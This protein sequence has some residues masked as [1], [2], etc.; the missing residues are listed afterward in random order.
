MIQNIYCDERE[1]SAETF[2]SRGRGQWVSTQQI[3]GSLV[4]FIF[5]GD[6]Y[7]G[8]ET[9]GAYPK[10]CG[11]YEVFS[12]EGGEYYLKLID[13]SNKVMKMSLE[14]EN[15]YTILINGRELERREF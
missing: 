2:L 10:S 7:C 13:Q 3:Q 1:G 6:I 12:K 8:G 9:K 15:D 11:R 4:L 5:K 14:I